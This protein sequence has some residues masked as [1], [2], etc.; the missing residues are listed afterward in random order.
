MQEITIQIRCDFHLDQRTEC[1]AIMLDLAKEKAEEII[2]TAA[3]MQGK[4]PP[5]VSIQCGDAFSVVEP[6]DAVKKLD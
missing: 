6:V 4:R 3:M 5:S 2:A 1:E